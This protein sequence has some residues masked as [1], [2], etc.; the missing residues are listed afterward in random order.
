MGASLVASGATPQHG[1][2]WTALWTRLW[3]YAL[4][5]GIRSLSLCGV[6]EVAY[7]VQMEPLSRVRYILRCAECG[8]A[9]VGSARG[10]RAY[11]CDLDD[12]GQDD[13]ICYCARC[14]DEQLGSDTS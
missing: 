9:A 3:N 5:C 7:G 11:L 4:P 13:V 12:D 2:L 6:D 14:A 8:V 10:W 1:R